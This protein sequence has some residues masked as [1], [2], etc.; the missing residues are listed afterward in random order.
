M[1]RNNTPAFL[2]RFERRGRQ[3][4]GRGESCSGLWT[5]DHTEPLALKLDK[6]T[7]TPGQLDD[8]A[9]P[10]HQRPPP[11]NTHSFIRELILNLE[12][13]SATNPPATGRLNKSPFLLCIQALRELTMTAVSWPIWQYPAG[14]LGWSG[15]GLWS[16][17]VAK[18]HTRELQPACAANTTCKIWKLTH[19]N[20]LYVFQWVVFNCPIRKE[21]NNK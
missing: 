12:E 15:R 13:F 2:V 7:Q 6:W 10:L 14:S 3:G 18:K 21:R 1:R 4:S 5:W 11:H 16:Q 20:L 9:R 19:F 17:S 8:R